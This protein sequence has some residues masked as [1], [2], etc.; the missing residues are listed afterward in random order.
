MVQ[1]GLT[2]ME[3][4]KLKAKKIPKPIA[5][6][7]SEQLE[8][9]KGYQKWFVWFPIRIYSGKWAWW[10]YV[11]RHRRF[12]RFFNKSYYWEYHEGDLGFRFHV[13]GGKDM[14][15]E[16]IAEY[17]KERGWRLE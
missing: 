13:I 1:W 8:V 15:K 14:S 11:Y 7:D 5:R 10:E 3:R 6:I 4:K 16:E 17:Y 12:D 9:Q 2:H